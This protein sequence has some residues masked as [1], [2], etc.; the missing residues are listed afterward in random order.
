MMKRWQEWP[1]S[2]KDIESLMKKIIL[3]GCKH[4]KIIIQKCEPF[5][6]HRVIVYYRVLVGDVFCQCDLCKNHK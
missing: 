4:N 2:R 3:L 6:A 5:T 1:G